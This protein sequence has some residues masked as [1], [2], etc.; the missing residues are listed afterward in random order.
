[1]TTD[2]HSPHHEGQHEVLDSRTAEVPA[3]ATGSRRRRVATITVA[4]AVVLAL[5][6]ATLARL[7]G[8]GSTSTASTPPKLALTPDTVGQDGIQNGG[9][10]MSS[11]ANSPAPSGGPVRVWIPAPGNITVSGSLPRGPGSAP[12]VNLGAS[13]RADLSAVR[14]L[15]A[16]LGLTGSPVHTGQAWTV[17][18][19]LTLLSVADSS[20]HPWT[21]LRSGGCSPLAM[22]ALSGQA[23]VMCAGGV[24]S[25]VIGSPGSSSSTSAGSGSASFGS[26]SGSSGAGTPGSLPGSV[27]TTAPTP[28]VPPTTAVPPVPQPLPVLPKPMPAPPLPS[29]AA[30]LAAARPVFLAVGLD[31]AHASTTPGFAVVDPT[32]DGLR[33][34]GVGTSVEVTRNGNADTI[35]FANG[36]LTQTHDG[37]IYP[38][39]SAS[40]ALRNLQNLPVPAIGFACVKGSDCQWRTVVTGATLGLELA[41][42]R[43]VPLLVPEWIFRTQ[44]YVPG[45]ESP[46]AGTLNAVAIDPKFLEPAA[47]GVPTGPAGSTGGSNPAGVATAGP[48]SIAP[49]SP[50]TVPSPVSTPGLQ[51]APQAQ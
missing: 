41:W 2:Q 5:G 20:G 46:A 3:P 4:G 19:G 7:D 21:F 9:A 33:T 31:P 18:N 1:M 6:V 38:V 10:G 30:T 40:A 42:N 16:A 23:G 14:A 44:V 26:A 47:S 13:G 27:P 48:A 35:A 34:T 39:I 12:V 36:W 32:I 28:P 8:F 25:G 24:D 37:A 11:A 22:H 45:A 43:G 51:V 29:G 17:R 49:G 50:A 15:A